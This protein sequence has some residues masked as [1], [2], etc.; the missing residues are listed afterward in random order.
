MIRVVSQDTRCQ[1]VIGSDAAGRAH[2]LAGEQIDRNCLFSLGNNINER[3]QTG[4]MA[5]TDEDWTP[6]HQGQRHHQRRC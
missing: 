3:V 2:R 1:I 4:D 5:T 6:S